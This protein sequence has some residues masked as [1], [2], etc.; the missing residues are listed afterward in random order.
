M[1]RDLEVC[2]IWLLVAVGRIGGGERSRPDDAP[3][4]CRKTSPIR[5]RCARRTRGGRVAGGNHRWG[6]LRVRKAPTTAQSP[7]VP[8]VTTATIQ[9]CGGGSVLR[10]RAVE[11]WPGV[12]S[13]AAANA[14]GLVAVADALARVIVTSASAIA[15]AVRPG[16]G[17][18]RRRMGRRRG[19]EAVDVS[20]WAC[21]RFKTAAG[22]VAWRCAAGTRSGR[23]DC[24]A[25]PSGGCSLRGAGWV[26]AAVDSGGSF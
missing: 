16:L 8:S 24:C 15:A 10:W 22:A 1:A 12:V 6:S 9:P 2:P 26:R 18:F 20:P 5:S 25:D 11:V 21:W 3:L 14:A 4:G 17:R 19:Q 13:V 7:T 23:P